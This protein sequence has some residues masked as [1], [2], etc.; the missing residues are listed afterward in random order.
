MK[1]LQE[2][3]RC[4]VYK[5][6]SPSGKVYIGI[7][8]MDIKDR[9]QNGNGY[10]NNQHF[11]RAI[12]KYGWDNFEHEVLFEGLTKED[13]CQ[14][15]IELI[16]LYDSTNPDKGYNY[17]TGGDG[18]A[19]IVLSEETRNKMRE[20]K[21]GANNP[22]YGKPIPDD[23]RKKMSDI[24]KRLCATEEGKERMAKIRAK[25]KPGLYTHSEETRK[26]L[27]ESHMGSKNFNYGKPMSEEQKKKLSFAISKP[28]VQL[29]EQYVLIAEYGSGK[30]AAE[31]TGLYRSNICQCCR[32]KLNFTGGFR[33][34]YKDD[35][36]KQLKEQTIQND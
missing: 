34:M 26:K 17:S 16:K 31:V 29:T 28:V 2:E 30:I 22:N 1:K 24:H 13:A 4:C 23:T 36:E 6:T 9:W 25:L 21:I 19:G 33:W 35:Y 12:Q 8:S 32:G 27:S 7:T 15:E 5:H 18:P 10:K 14:K 20:S 11:Y 3:R